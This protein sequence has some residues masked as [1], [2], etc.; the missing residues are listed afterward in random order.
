MGQQRATQI[1]TVQGTS[2]NDASSLKSPLSARAPRHPIL[3]LQKTI[4]NR[5]VQRLIQDQSKIGGPAE[6]L[7]SSPSLASIVNEA[8]SSPSQ[9]LDAE[10]RPFMEYRLGYDFSQVRLHTDS[11][12]ANS[13]RSMNA[14]AYTVGSDIVFGGG[15]YS[16]G[17][18]EGHRLIAHELTHV[19]QQASGPVAGIQTADDE[20]SISE[21]EDQSEQEAEQIA[22]QVLSDELDAEAPAELDESGGA[23]SAESLGQIADSPVVANSTVQRQSDDDYRQAGD[24]SIGGDASEA[25]SDSGGS[26][27][28]GFLETAQNMLSVVHAA[29][30]L[31]E[32]A[33]SEAAINAGEAGAPIF[34]G[35]ASALGL[36]EESVEA[37]Q[38]LYAAGQSAEEMVGGGPANLLG[39]LA[40]ASG[41][42]DVYQALTGPQSSLENTAKGVQGAA[43]ATSGAVG[44]AGLLGSLTGSAG[45]AE[46]AAALGPVGAVA[47]SF[48]GGMALGNFIEKYTGIGSKAGD[49]AYDVLGPK[50]GLWL[51]DHLPSW[52]Q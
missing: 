45:L 49:V 16:P 42:S 17:S 2:R 22:T 9:A 27:G 7:S 24:Q 25:V 52:L 1:S 44:T 12:A 13:A 50:P 18:I 5:A 38:S 37:G 29:T 40:L 43:E 4:G 33:V 41:A 47:G 26:E 46:G 6:E 31:P 15:E 30:E 28:G 21:P 14:K 20:I 8:L 23:S 19:V 10:T 35:V 51:A 48:A 11:Q 39:P 3:K 32:A 36:G 34:P